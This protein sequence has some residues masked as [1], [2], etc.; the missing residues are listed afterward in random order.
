MRWLQMLN[1]SRYRDSFLDSLV[2]FPANDWVVGCASFVVDAG[3]SEAIK[4]LSIPI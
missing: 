1:A 4:P 2:P 3:A